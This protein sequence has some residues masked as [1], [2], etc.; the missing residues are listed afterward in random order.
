[1]RLERTKSTQI[2]WPYTCYWETMASHYS[3]WFFN[4]LPPI[5]EPHLILSA[6]GAAEERLKSFYSRPAR[7]KA[8]EA[9]NKIAL[10]PN[11]NTQVSSSVNSGITPTAVTI[12]IKAQIQPRALKIKANTPTIEPPSY[13]SDEPSFSNLPFLGKV[14]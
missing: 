4:L 13:L 9:R 6:I 11:Q 10:S 3:Y 7:P 12:P 14:Y 2:G 8:I 1:M 5:G